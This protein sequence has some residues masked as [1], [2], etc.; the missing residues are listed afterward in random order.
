[1]A[2]DGKHIPSKE[3]KDNYDSIFRKKKKKKKKNGQH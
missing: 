2:Q 1:M 3:F